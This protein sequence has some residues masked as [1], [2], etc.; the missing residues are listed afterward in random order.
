[1][2]SPCYKCKKRAPGCHSICDLYK[3]YC[4][5]RQ[6]A[7]EARLKTLATYRKSRTKRVRIKTVVEKQV[8]RNYERTGDYK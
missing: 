4:E 5:E 8:Q 1:M 6:Q 2:N 7:S 3:A